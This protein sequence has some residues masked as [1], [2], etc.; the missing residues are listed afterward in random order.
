[1]LPARRHGYLLR[2]LFAGLLMHHVLRIPGC[3]V[4]VGLPCL[5]L[6]LPVRLRGANHRLSEV[7]HRCIYRVA[8]NTPRKAF[9]DFL[10]Q[11]TVAIRIVE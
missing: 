5:F 10:Q 9:R 7:T 1:M 4:G 6:M 11:P 2:Q 3:P 8:C